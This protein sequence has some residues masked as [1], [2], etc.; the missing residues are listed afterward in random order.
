MPF[1]PVQTL[2]GGLLLHLSTS[3]LLE[4]TGRVFGI[5]GILDGAVFGNHEKW[6]WGIIIGL[7][8]GPTLS[9]VTGFQAYYP[10]NALGSIAQI[11]LGRLGLAGALVGFGSRLGSGCTSGHMLCGVSR[12]SPR[13]LVATTT[14]FITAVLSAKFFPTNLSDPVIPAHTLEIPPLSTIALFISLIAGL[15]FTYTALRRYLLTNSASTSFRSTPYFITG[16][17]FSIGLSMSGMSDPVKVLGFL[18]LFDLNQFDPSL[19][20]IM[21]S[22]VLF[23]G[24]HYAKIKQIGKARFPWEKWQVPTRKDINF[25]LVFGS[26][27]FGL[28]WGLLGICPGPALVAFGD[29]LTR[30][31]TDDSSLRDTALLDIITFLGAMLGGMGFSGMF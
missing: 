9:Y 27:T 31:F 4:D 2:L 1:T 11:G 16:L 3:S 8:A 29:A 26:V 13:S 18:R 22:G 21:L 5:S 30:L 10:G 15:R 28:G 19:A 17:I 12:L 6:Q 14:F 20:L 24:I 7:L 23:N 25:K